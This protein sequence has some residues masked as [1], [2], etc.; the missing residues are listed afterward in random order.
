[1]T[2]IGCLLP[3]LNEMSM[4]VLQNKG[5]GEVSEY[6]QMEDIQDDS[7][8]R[9]DEYVTGDEDDYQQI[10]DD[11]YCRDCNLLTVHYPDSG[12]SDYESEMELKSCSDSHSNLYSM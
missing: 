2:L 3:A 11:S 1:M 9:E 10:E 6:P 12:V 4:I 7:Y 5:T 8:C